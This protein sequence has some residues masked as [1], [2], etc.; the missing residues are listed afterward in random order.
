MIHQQLRLHFWFHLWYPHITM[1]GNSKRP[2]DSSLLSRC[3][4]VPTFPFPP[5]QKNSTV[6]DS[7][8][9]CLCLP[10]KLGK[11]CC[12]NNKKNIKKPS[13]REITTNG[14]SVNH[15]QSWIGDRWWI[16]RPRR[17]GRSGDPPPD[18]GP[19]GRGLGE[20]Y[21][22]PGHPLNFYGVYGC[23]S[24]TWWSIPRIVSG[25][26]HPRYQW[27]LP[28]LIPLKSPGL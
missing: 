27:T 24:S 15:S 4:N 25:L 20:S 1:V 5:G 18:D 28:P 17:L 21:G 13:P 16:T 26:V 2:L 12:W 22:S 23:R 14:C 7:D 10:Y 19:P 3:K 11:A 6:Q 8:W 9:V